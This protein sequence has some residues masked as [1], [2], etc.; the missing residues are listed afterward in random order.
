LKTWVDNTTYHAYISASL[1]EY[2]FKSSCSDGFNTKGCKSL[3]VLKSDIH[4][5]GLKTQRAQ[6]EVDMLSEAIAHMSEFK[7]T[8]DGRHAAILLSFD[9]NVTAGISSRSSIAC[10]SGL[11]END[12]GSFDDWLSTSYASSD[13]LSLM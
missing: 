7:H 8:D 2:K 5:L 12:V 13:I 3:E 6:V 9:T 4:I 1:A 11:P 10:A